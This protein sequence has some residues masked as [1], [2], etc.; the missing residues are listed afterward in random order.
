MPQKNTGR[1]KAREICF[2]GLLGAL[3]VVL[4]IAE[5]MLPVLPFLP[6]G[7]KLGLSNVAVMYAVFFLGAKQ[8][9][10]VAVLKSAFVFILR[11]P[12]AAAMSLTGGLLSVCIMLLL[13]AWTKGRLDT[14]FLSIAGAVGHNLGQLGMSVLVLQSAYALYYLPVMLLSGV[15]M[16]I[17]TGLLL[18]V[19]I[20]ALEHL[21]I[22]L[23]K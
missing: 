9:I 23:Y 10:A 4:A 14:L 11:A 5:G 12:L 3:A 13:R 22:Y 1:S 20:P 19:V 17:A 7:V 15:A 6:P 2:L 8:A 16:G 18:R 21:H